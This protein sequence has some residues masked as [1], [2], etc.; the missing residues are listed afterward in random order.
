MKK[1][2]KYSIPILFMCNIALSMDEP[3]ADIKQDEEF[4]AKVIA[5]ENAFQRALL[6]EHSSFRKLFLDL[7]PIFKLPKDLLLKNYLTL[8]K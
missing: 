3:G 5:L 1:I 2:L 8:K 6:F 4:K 7:D